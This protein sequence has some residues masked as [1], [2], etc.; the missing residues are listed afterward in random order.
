M[1]DITAGF[2]EFLQIPGRGTVAAV[3]LAKVP[4][5]DVVRLYEHIKI[6]DKFYKI[7]GIEKFGQSKITGLLVKEIDDPT[8]TIEFLCLDVGRLHKGKEECRMRLCK[9]PDGSWYCIDC[10]LIIPATRVKAK[11][12]EEEK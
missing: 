6:Q 4:N 9:H 8:D 2:E 3:N 5:V 1:I 11:V 12:L 7:L 10:G